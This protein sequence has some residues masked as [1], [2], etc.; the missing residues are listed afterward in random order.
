V[1]VLRETIWMSS[2]FVYAGKEM[3]GTP[4]VWRKF[5]RGEVTMKTIVRL[6]I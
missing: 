2:G 1:G 4:G 5:G 3:C 6:G